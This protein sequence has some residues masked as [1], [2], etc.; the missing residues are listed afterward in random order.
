M[1]ALPDI[2]ERCS[3]MVR[4]AIRQREAT[5]PE[6]VARMARRQW[7]RQEQQAHN[8]RFAMPALP[9]PASSGAT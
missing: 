2:S 7:E 5:S 3:F 9:P 8:R 6:R 1:T 4:E